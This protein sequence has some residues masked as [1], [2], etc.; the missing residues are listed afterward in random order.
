MINI[1]DKVKSKEYIFEIKKNQVLTVTAIQSSW[2]G[3]YFLHFKE[4][5]PLL[6]YHAEGFEKC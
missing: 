4:V 1:G 6:S 5:T 3:K 2:D